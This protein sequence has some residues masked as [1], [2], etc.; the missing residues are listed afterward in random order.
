MC[1]VRNLYADVTKCFVTEMCILCAYVHNF[2]WGGGF[3]FTW[4]PATDALLNVHLVSGAP[5]LLLSGYAAN[6]L[7]SVDAPSGAPCC[8]SL[9]CSWSACW[10]A[11][12]S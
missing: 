9:G 4:C 12:V 1:R 6:V 10:A 3:G 2:E 5:C 8:R 7:P 11:R